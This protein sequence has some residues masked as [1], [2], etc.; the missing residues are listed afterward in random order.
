MPRRWRYSLR[1]VMVLTLVLAICL[2]LPVKSV[3]RQKAGRQWVN[4]QNGHVLFA[5]QFDPKTNQYDHSARPAPEWLVDLVGIDW[6]TS[7]LSITLDNQLI[8]DLTPVVELQSLQSIHICIEIDD[9]LDFSPL[10]RLPHLQ[11]LTL[12]YTNLSES[13]LETLRQ[14]LPGVKV[15]QS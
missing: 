3:L 10:A 4:S 8:T 9:D 13:E 7:V 5:H 2:A 14:Q 15:T 6:F 11:E 1:F 12:M